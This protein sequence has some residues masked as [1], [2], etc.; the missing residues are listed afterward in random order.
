[1][2]SP[3]TLVAQDISK[4]TMNTQSIEEMVS[5]IFATRRI[6]RSDQHVLMTMFSRGNISA[7]DEMLI[8]Q[9]YEALNQGR[10]RVVE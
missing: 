7:A 10:V 1:M 3:S 9:I 8:N 6:T 2:Q 4:A 5:K